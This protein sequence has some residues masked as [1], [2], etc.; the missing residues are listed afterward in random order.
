MSQAR[1]QKMQREK[2]RRERAAAKFARK[3]ERRET[4]DAQ[5]TPTVAVNEADTL[6]ELADLHARFAADELTFEEFEQ[7]KSRL[8]DQLDVR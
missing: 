2:Q 6:A 4:A 8:T 7:A 5:T 1:F 3:Q